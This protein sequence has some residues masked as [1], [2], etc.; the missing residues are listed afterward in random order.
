M[1]EKIISCEESLKIIT[2]MILTTRT[3]MERKCAYPF[4]VWG[5]SSVVIAITLHFLINQTDNPQWYW[6]WWVLPIIGFGATSVLPKDRTL[7]PP[8]TYFD[9]VIA[10]MWTLITI[11]MLAFAAT[12]MFSPIF[13]K[14]ILM[15]QAML[16][17]IGTAVTG[18]ILKYKYLQISAYVSV[19]LALTMIFVEPE[20]QM[21]MFAGVMIIMMVI[22][23]IVILRKFKK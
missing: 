12:S 1:E 7:Q 5:I 17:S 23:G 15:I 18:L 10:K 19:A 2:E 13:G 22:P 3:R 21:L 6:L 9:K 4:L 16:L 14:A 8:K 20:Y 11:I